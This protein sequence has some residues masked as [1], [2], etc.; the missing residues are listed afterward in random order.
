M[1]KVKDALF[2]GVTKATE[3]EELKEKRKV[4]NSG[5]LFVK[6]I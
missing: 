1:C 4:E 5:L 3:V 6:L 2:S